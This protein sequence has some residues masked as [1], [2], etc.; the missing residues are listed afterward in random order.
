VSVGFAAAVIRRANLLPA[1]V[2]VAVLAAG[3]TF[4]LALPAA[5]AY[6]TRKA[7]AAEVRT[8]TESVPDQLGVFHARDLAFDLGRDGPVPR[9]D[10]A[11]GLT[12]AIRA[13]RVRW[14]VAR[15][16]YLA[17]VDLPARI[18]LNEERFPWEGIDQLGDKMVLLEAIPKSD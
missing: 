12:A 18:V 16:R 13:G 5:D 1:T 17:G 10:S 15:T 7:F 8:R 2:A 14:V 11:E 4:L 6:R 9:Y 3:Y